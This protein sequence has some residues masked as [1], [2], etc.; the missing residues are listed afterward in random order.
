MNISK[1]SGIKGSRKEYDKKSMIVIYGKK[2]NTNSRDLG[3]RT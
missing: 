1:K 3:E 2:E